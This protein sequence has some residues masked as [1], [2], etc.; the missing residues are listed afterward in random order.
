MHY[1]FRGRSCVISRVNTGK[2]GTLAY[3]SFRWRAIRLFNSL[4]KPICDIK[5]C[6]V[7]SFKQRLDR[8]FNSIPDLP[9]YMWMQ[10][11][12]YGC[13]MSLKTVHIMNDCSSQDL[14]LIIVHQA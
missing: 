9:C 11:I 7:C 13:V 12:C 8:Y 3:N 1:R 4:P 14:R 2:H 5:N 6:F 10:T